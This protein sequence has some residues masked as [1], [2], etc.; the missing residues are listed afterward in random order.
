MTMGKIWMIAGA[1]LGAGF[2][3][4]GAVLQHVVGADADMMI[5]LS[6]AQHYHMLHLVALLLVGWMLVRQAG[7]GGLYPRLLNVSAALFLVGILLFSGNL[8]LKAVSSSAYMVSLVPVGGTMF[9]L[10]WLVLAAAL[11]FMPKGEVI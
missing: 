11:V 3:I 1:L 4:L 6:K 9:I 10:G 8:Y 5:I 7:A 2:V